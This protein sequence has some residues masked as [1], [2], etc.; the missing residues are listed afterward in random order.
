MAKGKAEVKFGPII[1]IGVE[2]LSGVLSGGVVAGAGAKFTA[3]AEIGADDLLNNT[4]YKH[5]CGLCILGAAEW[6]A[7]AE[8]KCSYKFTSGIKGDIVKA[9]ILDFS[10]PIVFNGIPSKFFIS[11]INS[12]D[13]PFGGH[14]KLGGGDCTNKAYRTEFKVQDSS[15]HNIDGICVSVVK[16]GQSE[17]KTGTAPYVV[18]LYDGIYMVSAKIDGTDVSKTIAVNGDR[19][20][21]VLSKESSDAVLEGT[22]VD[23]NGRGNVLADV[24]VRISMGDV[25]IEST[26]T[27]SNG[28]FCAIVPSGSLTVEFFKENYLPFRSTETVHDGDTIHSMGQVELTRGSGMGGL[29]GVIRDA[30]TSDPIADVTLNLYEGWNNQAESNTAIITLKTDSN[31]EFRC[32]TKVLAGH[33]IGLPSGNYTLTATKAGYA[34]TSYNIIVY[35]GATD[36]SPSINE[37]MSPEMN[38]GFYRIVLTWGTDPRDL[39]SHLVAETI[40]GGKI[41]VYYGDKNPSPYYANL[42]VDDTD[43]E[44]PETITITNF[45]EL[46][47]IK[48]AVHDFTNRAENSS[49]SLSNSNAVV[50]IY[51]GNH[52]LRTF[53]VPVGYDGTE[54]DVFTLKTDGTIISNN[55]MTYTEDVKAVLGE[56]EVA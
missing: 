2:L 23:A 19:Q 47:D 37:T 11:V 4:D 44:G 55:K 1:D 9:K 24:I 50:R 22:V 28:K 46:K 21:I 52:L 3:E 18:Y 32:D 26:K 53:N 34:D 48:Y 6:Y 41:H 17:S 12:T 8:V 33:I 25:I 30:V 42:D 14:I 51:K 29:H 7:S 15:G 16:Q 56:A 20:T 10:T 5:A 31:G 13:S 27:D 38:D 36:A 39:D 54:W 40:Y 43:S 35:P 49:D 45:A